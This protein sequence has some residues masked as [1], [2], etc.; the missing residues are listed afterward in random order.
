M[1]ESLPDKCP[2]CGANYHGEGKT[3]E[4]EWVQYK[5]STEFENGEWLQDDECRIAQLEATLAAR[6]AELAEAKR[7]VAELEAERRALLS[8]M[9]GRAT[10]LTDCLEAMFEANVSSS[11]APGSDEGA[12]STAPPPGR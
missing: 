9:T 3:D 8:E 5:C 6:E 12:S 1:S 4:W 7:R 11:P 10:R 2:F